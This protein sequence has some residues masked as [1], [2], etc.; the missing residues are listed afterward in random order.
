MLRSPFCRSLSLCPSARY[1]GGSCYE[2]T[3]FACG[4]CRQFPPT[5]VD[6]PKQCVGVRFIR[7]VLDLRRDSSHYAASSV[8]GLRKPAEGARVGGD[9]ARVLLGRRL[10]PPEARA[11]LLLAQVR[12]RQTGPARHAAGVRSGLVGILRLG[13]HQAAHRKSAVV[14]VLCEQVGTR[15]ADE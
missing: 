6:F 14:R 11:G 5:R 7:S 3:W 10:R 9:A 4:T 1:S 2:Q 13:R 15:D 8:S 12:F